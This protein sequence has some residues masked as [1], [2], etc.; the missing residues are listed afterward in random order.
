MPD[1][2]P[3]AKFGFAQG[4][5]SHRSLPWDTVQSVADAKTTEIVS[6]IS[7]DEEKKQEVGLRGLVSDW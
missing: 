4:K 2:H 6:I 1:L 3:G 7:V 5:K